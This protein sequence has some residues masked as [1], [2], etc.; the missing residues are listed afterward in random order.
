MDPLTAFGLACNL[1]TVVDAAVKCGKTIAELYDSTN[2]YTRETE[3]LRKAFGDLQVIE[4]DLKAS[5]LQIPATESRQRMQD[6]AA[7]CSGIAHR[8]NEILVSCAA[9]RPGSLRSAMKGFI[10][11]VVKKSEVLHLRDQLD[12]C[13]ATL[14]LLIA[15]TTQSD[16]A[17]IRSRLQ[18]TQR[19]H[20]LSLEKL[21]ELKTHLDNA[22]APDE[23]LEAIRSINT[24][25]HEAMEIITQDLIVRSI[26]SRYP[27]AKARFESVSK[28]EGGTFSWILED[29]DALL[30]MEP[31]LKLSFTEWLESGLGVFHIAGK[32]GSGKSTLMKFL[33]THADTKRRLKEW[34][35]EKELLFA[36]FFIWRLGG[37][38]QKTW[39]GM[40]GS[41]LYDIVQQVPSVT[42]LLF[43]DYWE[44]EKMRLHLKANSVIHLTEAEIRG[45][46]DKLI[47]DSEVQEKYRICFF[48]DGLDEFEEP[49]SSYWNLALKIKNCLSEKEGREASLLLERITRE[50]EGV[51]LWVVLLL[52]LLEEELAI[53]TETISMKHLHG[54]I[55]SA[56]KELEDFIIRIVET[57]P[58]QN[59]ANAMLL[60]A[61]ALRMNGLRIEPRPKLEN[62][63]YR[64]VPHPTGWKAGC[65]SL[66]GVS[67]YFEPVD[68]QD[69]LRL[70]LHARR[71]T[72]DAA[73][74]VNSWCR[75]LLAVEGDVLRFSHRSIPEL[76][77]KLLRSQKEPSITDET[78]LTAIL[79]VA[80]AEATVPERKLPFHRWERASSLVSRKLLRNCRPR[81]FPILHAIEEATERDVF[82]PG[83]SDDSWMRQL[84][85]QRFDID[86]FVED[87]SILNASAR[88]GPS[89]YCVWKVENHLRF[90]DDK[91]KMETMLAFGVFGAL[92]TTTSTDEPDLTSV[93]DF[94]SILDSCVRK[95]KAAAGENPGS[96]PWTLTWLDFVHYFLVRPLPLI[97]PKHV[98]WSLL[99]YWLELGLSSPFVLILTKPWETAGD[100]HILRQ[101]TP[102]PPEF[103]YLLDIR[104][105]RT[106]N[107]YPGAWD[108]PK[109][110]ELCKSIWEFA[111]ANHRGGRLSLRDLVVF[112]NPPNKRHLLQLIEQ[113]A[114]NNPMEVINVPME[115]MAAAGELQ[116]ESELYFEKS[117]K[118]EEPPSDEA[119]LA[120]PE[121]APVLAVARERSH[122][123]QYLEIIAM[124]FACVAFLQYMF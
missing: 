93:L 89:E 3:S 107:S 51:F 7:E 92:E 78:V 117:E 42:K 65:L 31:G 67:L 32:P 108:L 52:K 66:L 56:P 76:L 116:R 23:I 61:M 35:G 26:Q 10:K 80:L 119:E 14:A 20:K 41:L 27:A 62:P 38:D 72:R 60:L 54:I 105:G 21:D 17:E 28:A 47:S 74:L 64:G 29:P 15:A 49:T 13:S 83:I 109:H 2:G 73:R 123:E 18:Q 91:H 11:S 90:P 33:V 94:K 115:D 37:E 57:I 84:S 59:R 43:A 113:N 34:A 71:R 79:N 120:G 48:I 122:R 50:A 104:Y 77:Q 55:D 75:G 16:V 36:S 88:F 4:R 1:L 19:D 103:Q 45:A 106:I 9:Q 112:Y 12:K 30:D 85:I 110:I 100:G 96:F 25:S 63:V 118:S 68:R 124:F 44:T 101:L 40:V 8:I 22:T 46:F 70:Q 58:S 86:G 87:A 82:G 111:I 69:S 121:E 81:D 39:N 99:E 5:Q 24:T 97:S 6:A 95:W 53:R 98:G 102:R 114:S